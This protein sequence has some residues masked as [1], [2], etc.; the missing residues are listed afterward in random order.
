M[1]CLQSSPPA[2]WSPSPCACRPET[3]CHPQTD[4]FSRKNMFIVSLTLLTIFGWSSIGYTEDFWGD[5]GI[6]ALVFIV[7]AFGSGILTEVGK[8]AQANLR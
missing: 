7:V 1:P 8:M 6:I 3:N 4:V 2:S 5:L